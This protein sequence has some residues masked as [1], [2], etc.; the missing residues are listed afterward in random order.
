MHGAHVMHNS[1]PCLISLTVLTL[2]FDVCER[3]QLAC[4]DVA[5]RLKET[6]E[7]IDQAGSEGDEDQSAQESMTQ[8]MDSL[9]IIYDTK[10]KAGY[11]IFNHEG[12]W[13]ALVCRMCAQCNGICSRQALS[14]TLLTGRTGPGSGQGAQE[15]RGQGN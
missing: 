9:Y 14:T 12:M 4:K 3:L 11:T 15:N 10:D 7:E 13:G 8:A 2:S 6:S 1:F 5:D